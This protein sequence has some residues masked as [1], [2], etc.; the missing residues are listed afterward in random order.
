MDFVNQ[1]YTTVADF[2]D[3]RQVP[4]LG[5]KSCPAVRCEGVEMSDAMAIC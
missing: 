4:S 5:T 1:P 3:D 2:T